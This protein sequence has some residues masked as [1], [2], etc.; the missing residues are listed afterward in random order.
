VSGVPTVTL[1]ERTP[2]VGR[3]TVVGWGSTHPE[4]LA[5]SDE[6]RQ[7]EL[8]L[9]TSPNCAIAMAGRRTVTETMVCA[10]QPQGGVDAC[11]ADDGGP[12]LFLT[13]AGPR[14][15]GIVSFS[16]GCAK[17]ATPAVYTSVP[18]FRAWITARLSEQAN[19]SPTPAPTAPA[20]RPT[21]SPTPV[22]SPGT[23]RVLL[24]LP[25]VR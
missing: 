2:A 11:K 17:P 9:I 18:A 14:Q 16:D 1:A 19:T 6:L 12:L 20:P 15:V 25:V 23:A 10:G 13:T 8:P 24:Y 7:A 3:V 4:L 5:L 22:P 21:P